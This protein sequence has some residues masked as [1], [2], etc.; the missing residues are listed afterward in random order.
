M[1]TVEFT[2]RIFLYTRENVSAEFTI[3]KHIL[4]P[5]DFDYIYHS[6]L[7]VSHD[8]ELIIANYKS[9]YM[10]LYYCSMTINES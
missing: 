7:V 10:L 5:G 2:R 6:S 3:K 9:G 1:G 8:G 4:F